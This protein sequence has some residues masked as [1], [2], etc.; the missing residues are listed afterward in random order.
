MPDTVQG[1]NTQYGFRKYDY[2]ALANLP[3]V[4]PQMYGAVGDGVTDDTEAIQ[5]ALN[6][7]NVLFPEGTY[8]ISSTLTLNGHNQIVCATSGK[9]VILAADTLASEM[10]VVD[11][12]LSPA[13]RSNQQLSNL[14]LKGNGTCTGIRFHM[15]ADFFLNNVQISD[16][17]WGLIF[18]DALMYRIC[19]TSVIGC[20]NGIKFLNSTDLSASNNA[21]FEMC[22][23]NSIAKFAIYSESED[24]T[25]N[26]VFNCC[27]IEATN[28]S[29]SDIS[30]ITLQSLSTSGASPIMVFRNCWFESNHGTV[31]VS[32][33]GTDGGQKQYVFDGCTIVNTANACDYFIKAVGRTLVMLNQNDPSMYN[34]KT[35]S[36]ESGYLFVMGGILTYDIDD[37]NR[38]THL[39]YEGQINS[40]LTLRQGHGTIYKSAGGSDS[41]KIY[42]ES[43]KLKIVADTNTVL[44]D[45]A[46]GVQ[47]QNSYLKPLI[48]GSVY[49]WSYNNTIYVKHGSYPTAY[50]DGTVLITL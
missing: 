40:N 14:C 49:L 32:I 28:T 38:A 33:T 2:N 30:P 15:N 35:V 29:E 18:D 43:N 10:F 34:E 48:I 20:A 31:P 21:C 17:E 50:N 1:F 23:I 8:L 37:E 25:H 16:C 4:T 47:L 11:G 42:G 12:S 39:G 13:Y 24:S 19:A 9:T 46:K 5:T 27:E 3:Q 45:G 7:G 22:K 44:L 6:S 26:V 41:N 36:V